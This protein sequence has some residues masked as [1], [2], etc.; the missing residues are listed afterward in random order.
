MQGTHCA[1]IPLVSDMQKNLFPNHI[2][3]VPWLLVFQMYSMGAGKPETMPPSL[4]APD[5]N[6]VSSMGL[7]SFPNYQTQRPC[8]S[9]DSKLFCSK[10]RGVVKRTRTKVGRHLSKQIKDFFFPRSKRKFLHVSDKA[11]LPQSW[12]CQGSC[13]ISA[14]CVPLKQQRWVVFCCVSRADRLWALELAWGGSRLEAW[15]GGVSPRSLLPAAAWD[16]LRGAV[17]LKP[18]IRDS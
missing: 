14:C 3:T 2:A 10:S 13:L 12:S 8:T 15:R 7:G 5:L 9:H 6:C 18:G 4:K 17:Q 1:C 11:S 16:Q